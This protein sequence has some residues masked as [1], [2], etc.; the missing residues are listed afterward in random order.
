MS[1][2]TF[3][4][5]P[6]FVDLQD[7]T[8]DA[9]QPITDVGLKQINQNAKAGAVRCEIIYMGFYVHGNIVPT[10]MSPVDG[11]VYQRREVSYF[12]V[13]FSNRLAVQGFVPGQAT[14]P[15]QSDS[16]AG[17]LYNVN[18]DVNDATGLVYTKTSYWLNGNETPTNEGII[19]VYAICQRL[20]V[21]QTN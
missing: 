10:P 18:D 12:W 14:I 2:L 16:Q 15:V 3:S 21:N 6:G 4:T 9:G 5:Q 8:F 19:K 13:R 11:Y 1:Q 20:S 7:S 17:S